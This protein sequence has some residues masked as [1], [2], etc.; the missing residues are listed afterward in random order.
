M[1]ERGRDAGLGVGV[2]VA[3]GW[4]ARDRSILRGEGDAFSATY[5]VAIAD[6]HTPVDAAR[7]GVVAG[8]FAVTKREVVP[9]LGTWAELERFASAA[10]L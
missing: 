8:A 7:L 9:G 4:N 1:V 6:G 5:A 10:R 2:R 3:V